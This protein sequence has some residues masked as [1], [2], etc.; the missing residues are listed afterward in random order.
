M[1]RRLRAAAG[2][3]VY[4]VLNRA[5][6][7]AKLFTKA[8]DYAAFIKVLREAH[9]LLPMRLLAF[10]LMPNHWH[11]LLWPVADGDLSRYLHWLTMTHT[12]RWH[13]QHHTV[14]TGPLYQGR[15]KS[16]PVAEDEHLW[17]VWRYIEG[18]ALRAGLVARAEAWPWSS[19]ALRYRNAEVP[20]WLGAGPTP[21]PAGWLQYVNGLATAAELAA[22]RHCVVR[23]A[24]FGEEAWQLLAVEALGLQATL[25]PRGRPRKITR[26]K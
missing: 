3:Y 24:P 23:G 14:G 1:P 4:H 21:L 17:T 22:L 7:R 25:R 9:E 11:L 8:G 6:G 19:L 5:V 15:F 20:A 26:K 16:F 12:Q 2:G 13:S 10:C 18:N